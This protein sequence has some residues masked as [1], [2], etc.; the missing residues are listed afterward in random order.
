[1]HQTTVMIVPAVMKIQTNT[2]PSIFFGTLLVLGSFFVNG[3]VAHAQQG[4]TLYLEPATALYPV[5]ETF[6]VQ[7][8]LDTG[9][10]SVG[11]AD[12][13]IAYEPQ[14]LEFVSFSSE[15]SV[16]GSIIVPDE[17]APGRIKVQGVV[18]RNRGPFT[19]PDGLFATL[20]FRPLR[21]TATEVR[22]MQGAAT[23]LQA[24][25]GAA[26]SNILSGLNSATY[27][28]IPKGTVPAAAVAYAS[29]EVDFDITPIPVPSD[30]WFSTTSVRLSW[31]L[32]DNVTEMRTHVSQNQNDTPTKVYAIPVSS[33]ELSDLAQGGNYFHL[34]FR[35]GDEWGPVIH[36]PVRVDLTQP[37]FVI[38]REAE[39]SDPSDPR[40][41]FAIESADVPSGIA[42]YEMVIDNEE[43][44]FW[45]P[46][47]DGLYRPESLEPGQHSLT[48]FAFDRAGNST[49]SAVEFLVH[50]LDPPVLTQ[51]P[52]HVLTGNPITVR[53]TTYPNAEVT[54][55][56]SFDDGEASTKTV[57]SD[58]SGAFVAT[59]T[60]AGRAGKYTVWFSVADDRGA[61]SPPSIKRSIT[62]TQ[63]FIM[64]F[65]SIAVTYLS[66]IVPLVALI[67]VLG[68]ILWL[69]YTYIRTYRHRVR[70]ETGEAYHAV[71]DDFKRLRDDMVVQMGELEQAN[72]DRKLTRE[73][74]RIWQELRRK[75]DQIE[76]HLEDEIEDIAPVSDARTTTAAQDSATSI[77]KERATAAAAP[78]TALPAKHTL[79]IER[80]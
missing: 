39:R 52:D 15:G 30:E 45:E 71:Q 23:P 80:R 27:T 67:L 28:L 9:N 33:I 24:A 65:G 61:V 43:P 34:Q 68:L 35:F 25:V 72:H 48:V 46:T 3:V 56:T 51:A 53:G 73:E 22:F 29:E 55:F 18:S 66:V 64:L 44:V 62:V 13:L 50:S 37:D 41:A 36:Y 69:V 63:P 19:G 8:R 42:R 49:S 47:Q 31:T 40:I 17:A 6:D 26:V 21:S 70:R 57:Q 74:L 77:R 79:T 10:A 58:G 14:D 60:D 38:V 16:F 75:L 59:L 5:G 4:A 7:V 11:S 20:T 1:M 12:A 32:P 76:E 2:I 54:V 78:A